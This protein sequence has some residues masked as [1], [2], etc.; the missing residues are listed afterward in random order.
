MFLSL[1]NHVQGSHL[2]GSH[3]TWILPPLPPFHHRLLLTRFSTHNPSRLT[4]LRYLH[5]AIPKFASPDRAAMA[6]SCLSTFRTTSFN[7]WTPMLTAHSPPHKLPLQHHH[8]QHHLQLSH[9][10]PF[11]HHHSPLHLL[12][13]HHCHHF[14]NSHSRISRPI[15]LPPPSSGSLAARLLQ[16]LQICLERPSPDDSC[17]ITLLVSPG[18]RFSQP[19]KNHAGPIYHSA[20]H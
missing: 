7:T 3:P 9:R 2:T 19:S 17:T 11:H 6:T 4:H 1:R 14:Q 12:Y 18:Q 20:F 15:S 13:F 10:A 5:T 8:I 16:R